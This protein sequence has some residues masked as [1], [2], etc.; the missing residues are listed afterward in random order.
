MDQFIVRH[1]DYFF[2]R[3]PEQARLNPDN[4][5]ILV[6]HIKCA[7][8]ELPFQRGEVFGGEDLE[9]IL[10]YLSEKKVLRKLSDRWFWAEDA[11]PADQVSLRSVSAENFV[12]ID[13]RSGNRIIA[14]V[15]HDSAALTLYPGAIYMVES[16]PYQV[17]ELDYSN[18]KAFVAP[19]NAEYY[20]EAVLYTHL[21]ILDTFQSAP[22]VLK[23][24]CP[25]FREGEV[26]V[27]NHV[28]GFK[29]LKFYSS[30]NLGFGEVTL[31]DQEMHTSAF[32]IT[33][34]LENAQ[35]MG[36]SVQELLEALEGMGYAMLHMAS[37]LLMCDTR[38]IGRV[39]GD[40]HEQLFF[41]GHRGEETIE[42]CVQEGQGFVFRPT[43]FLY[44]A[45]PGG[46]GLSSALFSR[47]NELLRGT[48]SLIESCSCRKGCPSCVGPL[49]ELGEKAKQ[50]A[51]KVLEWMISGI[52]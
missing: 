43:L 8:F 24:G 36:L 15:D 17:E 44:D 6:S 1:P 18:H 23:T 30:E 52:D 31:P 19:V 21:K 40:P 35:Q 13:R 39:I 42:S 14:E 50:N 28:A 47:R 34:D 41:Q 16:Q 48:R 4:L 45:Y 32:W 25:L 5:A 2:G 11:Y 20:T 33:M 29:K 49:P 37:F 38:D 7:A 26:H 9:E 12:V 10:D 51:S 27:L 46:V 3:S 22:V